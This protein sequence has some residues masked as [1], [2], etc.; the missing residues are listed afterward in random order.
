MEF[1]YVDK[2]PER[3]RGGRPG[4]KSVWAEMYIRL[5]ASGKP[6]LKIVC[7]TRESAQSKVTSMRRAI[8]ENKLNATAALRDREVYMVL[9]NYV[10]KK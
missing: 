6:A 3:G 9:N 2:L 4:S 1:Q 10:P 8:R 7:E 5:V